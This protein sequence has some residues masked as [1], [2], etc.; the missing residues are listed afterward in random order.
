MTQ[1]DY[2]RWGKRLKEQGFTKKQINI[3]LGSM[4]THHRA[5]AEVQKKFKVSKP[6]AKALVSKAADYNIRDMGDLLHVV[7]KYLLKRK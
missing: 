7:E 3:T 2:V 1:F 6:K 4:A 5:V